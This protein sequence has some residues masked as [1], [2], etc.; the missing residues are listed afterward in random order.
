M[1]LTVSS[2]LN[3]KTWDAT[4]R[5]TGGHPNQLW[6]IGAV[7]QSAE[8]VN[9]TV[10]RV[11]VRDADERMVGYAQLLIREES[12][13]FHAEA[14]QAH[15]NRPATVPAFMQTLAGYV[16]DRYDA[17]SLTLSVD[18]PA[19]Q[20][21]TEAL[22]ERGWKRQETVSEGETGPRRLRVPLGAADS[23]LSARLS[24]DTLDR[25]RAGLKVSDVA[26]REITANS[27]SVRAVGLKTG[28]I[29]HLLKDLGQDSLLLVAAQERPD[30]QPEALGYLWFVH[31]VG[32]AMLYR[33]GFTRKARELGIDDA[34]LLTG[35]VELQKR[36]V[37]RMDGGDSA[38][39]DVPTVV[40][41]LA[42]R[43]R[44]VLGTWRKDLVEVAQQAPAP[45]SEPTKRRL[46]GRKKA[47][48]PVA[49]V[50]A[51]EEP[52]PPRRVDEVRQAVS[53]DLG[54]ETTGITPAQSD[55]ALGGGSTPDH[56]SAEG[57]TPSAVVQGNGARK[58]G[59]AAS[60]SWGAGTDDDG[61]SEGAPGASASAGGAPD[62]VTEPAENGAAATGKPAKLSKSQARKQRRQ[63]KRSSAQEQSPAESQAPDDSSEAAEA[64]HVTAEQPQPAQGPDA[65]DG[66]ETH[67]QSSANH[68]TDTL[69]TSE[70]VTAHGAESAS[71]PEQPQDAQ[72]RTEHKP[73]REESGGHSP[74]ISRKADALAR[75][76]AH[77]PAADSADGQ[78]RSDRYHPDAGSDRK[79]GR[80]PFAFGKRVYSDS[81]QA[82]KD[83]AGR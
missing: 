74:D 68:P 26:V 55:I 18:T 64:Q 31:T 66:P 35:A 51:P 6:G 80:G 82:F 78:E 75:Q 49:E 12:N 70:P 21:L 4:V 22:T 5:V 37:Q 32:L 3:Q 43:D 23:A 2:S 48:T 67:Q 38:D 20:P 39:K 79:R 13:S 34:L 81:V 47:Q 63:N 56:S 71:E 52:T 45:V 76:R 11:L 41:E 40:R 57:R 14:H 60:S 61:Q 73:Q 58:G 72:N 27:G 53:A 9:L 7:Q 28:Q 77:S 50:Q 8:G 65:Q 15:V 62:A 19:A 25:C 30:E 29:N 10:D 16:A 59:V 44:T 36:G 1:A 46:F 17:Q 69:A 33:I 24:A 42:D 83:A 54:I